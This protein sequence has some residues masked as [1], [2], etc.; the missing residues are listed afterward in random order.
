MV[1]LASEDFDVVAKEHGYRLLVVMMDK[2]TV[3]TA[4]VYPVCI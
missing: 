4:V 1:Y 2:W 3:N